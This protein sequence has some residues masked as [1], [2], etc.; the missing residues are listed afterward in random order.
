[1]L[2]ISRITDYAV[3]VLT[4]LAREA[5]VCVHPA[6]EI[7]EATGI[8]QPTVAKVLKGLTRE[9]LLISS[10]GV[11]GGYT[12]GK[13]PADVSIADVIEAM[14][15]PLAITA[16]STFGPDRCEESHHCHVSAHWPR[17]NAA[18]RS[19]LAE[20]SILSLAAPAADDPQSRRT[21]ASVGE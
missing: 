19:A 18:V 5:H 12:L 7:A 1:M 15:G 10:R 13:N 14:E 16:C 11:N 6:S 3:V 4:H 17:I 20:V 2:K 21:W 9:G 8:P